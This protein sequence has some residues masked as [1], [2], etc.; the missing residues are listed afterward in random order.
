MNGPDEPL[1]PAERRLDE[2]L[3]LLRASG[4][5]TSTELVQRVITAA[6]WQ[7]LL[8]HPLLVAANFAATIGDGLRLLLGSRSRR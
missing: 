1:S 5:H 7:R 8:R 3:E 6:R 2:H 4:P